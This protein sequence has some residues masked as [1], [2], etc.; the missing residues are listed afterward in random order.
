MTNDGSGGLQGSKQVYVA[1]DDRD[2][3]DAV[4][5]IIRGS[6]FTPVDMGLLSAARAIEDIP[7][8]VFASW[9]IPFYIHMAIFIFLYLLSFGKMMVSF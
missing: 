8:S 9:R 7:V 5:S 6:G 1:G 2:A 3:R 4:S